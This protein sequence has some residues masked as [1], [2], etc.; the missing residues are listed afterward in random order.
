MRFRIVSVGLFAEVTDRRQSHVVPVPRATRCP[1]PPRPRVHALR[2]GDT[3][4][5]AGVVF[6]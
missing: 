2:A 3:G 6:G 4:N 5:T 1:V